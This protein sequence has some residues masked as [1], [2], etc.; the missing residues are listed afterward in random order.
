VNGESETSDEELGPV[1][2]VWCPEKVHCRPRELQREQGEFL[3]QDAL[4]KKHKSQDCLFLPGLAAGGNGWLY[5][6]AHALLCLRVTSLPNDQRPFL[7][8]SRCGISHSFRNDFL[9]KG[10]LEE[11]C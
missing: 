5:F 4:A 3:S 2:S 1:D 10:Q 7:F 9:Q 11:G 8:H 6:F